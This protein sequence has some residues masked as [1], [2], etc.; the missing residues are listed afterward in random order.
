VRLLRQSAY[1]QWTLNCTRKFVLNKELK[2]RVY[3]PSKVAN[4]TLQQQQ[5]VLV[6]IRLSMDPGLLAIKVCSG[7]FRLLFSYPYVRKEPT[8]TNDALPA[9]LDIPATL[10]P[11]QGC[12]MQRCMPSSGTVR[13]QVWYPKNPG[14]VRASFTLT[15]ELQ[16]LKET[17][18]WAWRRHKAWLAGAATSTASSST[19]VPP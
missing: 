3:R 8:P 7:E 16:G 10:P 12:K 17:T 4:R 11:R 6:E 9:Q 2:K 13:F 5:C 14:D 19:S 15:N 1:D 18:A